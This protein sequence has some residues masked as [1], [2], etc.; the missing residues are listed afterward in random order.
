MRLNKISEIP[1]RSRRSSHSSEIETLITLFDDSSMVEAVI[2]DDERWFY[3]DQD[4]RRAVRRVLDTTNT[5]ND[6]KIFMRKGHVYLK[7]EVRG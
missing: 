5:K 1:C 2:V 3:H 4:L 6:I 7:K